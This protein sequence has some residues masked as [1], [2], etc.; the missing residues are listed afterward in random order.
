MYV[1]R[2][3]YLPVLQP[4]EYRQIAQ[5][6]DISLAFGSILEPDPDFPTLSRLD[7]HN[8]QF[9]SHSVNS[10]FRVMQ[11]LLILPDH[12]DTGRAVALLPAPYINVPA[13]R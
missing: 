2:L 13:T 12:S 5:V 8:V 1:H 6:A 10:L 11:L 4:G 9:N 3:E 7:F